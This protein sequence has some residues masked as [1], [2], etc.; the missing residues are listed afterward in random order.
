MSREKSKFI[1]EL[2]STKS[3]DKPKNNYVHNNDMYR[4]IKEYRKAARAARK[5]KL[6][7]PRITESL[8]KDIFLIATN[9]A[10]KPIFNNYPFKQDMIGDAIENCIMYFDN[11]DPRWSKYPHAYFSKISY[12]AFIRRIQREKKHLYIKYK[13]TQQ[14]GI[15][16]EAE[17]NEMPN[18]DQEGQF[19]MYANIEEFIG[20][21]EEAQEAAKKKSKETSKKN[22]ELLIE[23]DDK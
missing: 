1:P 6:P 5:A 10:H 15:L 11:F 23:P 17:L 16:H 14:A 9:L 7:K 22:L 4:K 8:G 18:A 13:A 12:Y 2:S 19:E 3:V 20:K 21:Y